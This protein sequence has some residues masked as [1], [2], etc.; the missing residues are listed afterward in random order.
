MRRDKSAFITALRFIGKLLPGN[1]LKTAFFVN[2]IARPRKSMRL[3]LNAFY[4]MEH[5]YEVLREAKRQYQGNFSIL[6]FGTSDGYAFTK[7]LYA[8]RYNGMADRVIVHGFD[9]FEGMPPPRGRIDQNV[10]TNDSW[11]EGEYRG[12]YEELDQYCRS[13][14]SNYR[15]HKGYFEST[16]T[17]E[18]L[19]S[20]HE[21]LPILVWID[22][23]YYSSAR[24]V[25]ER[26]VPH[27]P[28]GCVLYFD[29]YDIN[30]GSRLTGEA[31]AV[32]E[33]NTGHFGEGIELVP[34]QQLSLGSR[35]IYRFV[36][37]EH[38]PQ[39]QPRERGHNAERVRSRTNDSPLP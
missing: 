38:G 29:D 34:D 24:T 22:C 25:L 37:L 6:E 1:Y 5:V 36:R 9:S 31:R 2:V 32:H 16:L 18:F 20:L 23:D 13:R 7:M 27:L 19:A 14:Y 12:H 33:L 8:V 28:S 3:L 11:V 26:L 35:R 30:Y 10:V 4:R 39:F 15:L 21:N 17:D